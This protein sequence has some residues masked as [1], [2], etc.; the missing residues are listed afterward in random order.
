MAEEHDLVVMLTHGTAQPDFGA[1][2]FHLA[3]AGAALGRSVGLYLAVEGTSWLSD[4]AP[5]DLAAELRQ[6]RELGVVVYACPRS[7]DDQCVTPEDGACLPL[8]ATAFVRLALRSTTV[9]SL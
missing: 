3:A 8:G 7:L 9:V 1:H 6:L 4:A 5:A 2:A